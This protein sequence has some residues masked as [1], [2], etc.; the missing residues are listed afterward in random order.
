DHVHNNAEE[1]EHYITPELEKQLE[2][3]LENPETD[4]HGT[5]IPK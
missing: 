5:V 2:K 1:M 4:P 3:Y